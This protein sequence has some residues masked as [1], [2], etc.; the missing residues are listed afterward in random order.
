MTRSEIA[1][2]VVE[3]MED[4]FDEDDLTYDDSM[5][6]ADIEEWDSLSNI[7]FVV[8]IEK[9]FG[10]RFSNSEIA[11]LENVGQMVDLI[12]SKQG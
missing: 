3:L 10:I 7:R 8:G 5:T 1:S 12:L 11:D 2:K 9:E 4:V 6:A